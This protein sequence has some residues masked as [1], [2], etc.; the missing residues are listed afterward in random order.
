MQVERPVHSDPAREDRGA[1][2]AARIVAARRC[3]V[4]ATS[5][6]VGGVL[7]GAMTYAL[8]MRRASDDGIKALGTRPRMQP[9]GLLT[10]E[11]RSVAD[12]LACSRQLPPHAAIATGIAGG[13]LVLSGRHGARSSAACSRQGP[14]ARRPARPHAHRRASLFL[15]T[16]F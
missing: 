12:S 10:R 4:G 15:T 14:Q 3:I 2:A 11:Q 7:L 8:F 9:D 5:L 13:V 16:R 1:A 6:S